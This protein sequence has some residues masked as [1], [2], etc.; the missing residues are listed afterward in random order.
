MAS[1]SKTTTT[2]RLLPDIAVKLKIYSFSAHS[3]QTRLIEQALL[4]YFDKHK[5]PERYQLN[6]TKDH[7]VLV[8][9]EGDKASVVEVSPRN[10]APVETLLEKYSSRLRTPIEL[11]LQDAEGASP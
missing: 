2:V 3:S 4:E 11:I 6:V 8:L 5:I 1:K 7:T 9:L 10:G